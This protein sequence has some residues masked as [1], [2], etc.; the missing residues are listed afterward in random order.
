MYNVATI[1]T[2]STVLLYE[3]VIIIIVSCWRYFL[4]DIR[5]QQFRDH[6]EAMLRKLI[7]LLSSSECRR[8]L[9]T[10]LP[11]LAK[12]DWERFLCHYPCLLRVTR[13][14]P[15]SLSLFSLT[16]SDGRFLCHCSFIPL[17]RGTRG[18][19]SVIGEVPLSLSLYY[20]YIECY[21][22]TSVRI[23]PTISEV[24]INV[25][26]TAKGSKS[27]DYYIIIM[28]LLHHHHVI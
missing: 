15:L 23:C 12:R 3:H 2:S 6:K 20:Y 25:V 4:K 28:W 14:V 18:G 17:L 13:E 16:K 10:S 26:T 1:N 8:K 11:L 19:S 5:S 22:H 21:Y 9:V 24:M 7:T 27:H